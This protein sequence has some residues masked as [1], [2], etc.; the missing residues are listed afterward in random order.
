MASGSGWNLWVWLAGGGYGWNLWVWLVGVV[1]RRYIEFLTM[2]T[3]WCLIFFTGGG[4]T[5]VFSALLGQQR[6]FKLVQSLVIK[7]L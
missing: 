7:E 3:V 4:I 2:S 1:V 6:F 5:P